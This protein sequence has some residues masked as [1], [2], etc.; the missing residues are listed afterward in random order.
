MGY[1]HKDPQRSLAPQR[2]SVNE[3]HERIKEESFIIV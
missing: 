3:L 1:V 2:A